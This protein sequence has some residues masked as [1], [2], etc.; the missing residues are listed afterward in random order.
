MA[1]NEEKIEVICIRRLEDGTIIQK[2]CFLN[3]ISEE[4]RQDIQGLVI[5]PKVKTNGEDYASVSFT[6]YIHD[7]PMLQVITCPQQWQNIPVSTIQRNNCPNLRNIIRTTSN[8]VEP[9]NDLKIRAKYTTINNGKKEGIV[10]VVSHF[11]Q[12][13]GQTPVQFFEVPQAQVKKSSVSNGKVFAN[14]LDIE[15]ALKQTIIENKLS[16]IEEKVGKVAH[17]EEIEQ[18][19]GK[20]AGK[21][22][23][24]QLQMV[25]NAISNINVFVDDSALV[26]V[27]Q[28]TIEEQMTLIAEQDNETYKENIANLLKV[29]EDLQAKGAT[30]EQLLAYL[31]EQM[32]QV[33]ASNNQLT[34]KVLLGLDK[35]DEMSESISAVNNSLDTYAGDILG[36]IADLSSQLSGLATREDEKKIVEIAMQLVA[37]QTETLVR[38]KDNEFFDDIKSK[39]S[40]VATSTAL[41][42]IED[43]INT[44]PSKTVIL[45]KF[46]EIKNKFADVSKVSQEQL[47]RIISSLD[48]ISLDNEQ[49][50][51]QVITEI[52]SEFETNRSQQQ[53]TLTDAVA[54][55]RKTAL[56]AGTKTEA[57]VKKLFRDFAESRL[58][59][60]IATNR[61]LTDKL[62]PAIARME[63]KVD[64]LSDKVDDLNLTTS[65]ILEKAANLEVGNDLLLEGVADLQKDLSRLINNGSNLS[66]EERTNLSKLINA[67]VSDLH[68]RVKAGQ[69]EILDNMKDGFS[70]VVNAEQIEKIVANKVET[71][72]ASLNNL[73]TDVNENSDIVAYLVRILSGAVLK[74]L[75]DLSKLHSEDTKSIKEAIDK[76]FD[77]NKFTENMTAILNNS[78]LAK[79]SS[80]EELTKL[81]NTQNEAEV[82][83]LSDIASSISHLPTIDKIKEVVRDESSGL[84]SLLLRRLGL[85]QNIDDDTLADMLGDNFGFLNGKVKGME[86]TL[87]AI[88]TESK[89]KGMTIEDLKK[90]FS[91]QEGKQVISSALNV[92][93]LTQ[94]LAKI[95]QANEVRIAELQRAYE[96]NIQLVSRMA[97]NSINIYTG[98]YGLASGVIQGGGVIPSGYSAQMFQ[99]YLYAYPVSTSTPQEMMTVMQQQIL[100]LYTVLGLRPNPTPNPVD[101]KDDLKKQLEEFKKQQEEFRKTLQEE[102][103]KQ[104]E[105]FKKQ[106]EEINKK[107][108]DRLDQLE[109]KNKSSEDK[110]KDKD[111]KKEEEKNK[112]VVPAKVDP[113]IKNVPKE[114]NLKFVTKCLEKMDRLAEPKLTVGQRFRK[115]LKRH[116]L[117]WTAIG[118][119]AGAILGAGVGVFAA[120]G[121]APFIA[122]MAYFGQS[123]QTIAVGAG[124][125]LG[126][127]GIGEI[128]A[129]VTGFCK[130][131]RLYKKFLKR[132]AKCE[133]SRG[134]IEELDRQIEYAKEAINQTREVAKACVKAKQRKRVVKATRKRVKK[135]RKLRSKARVSK[136]KYK[137]VVENFMQAKNNLNDYEKKKGKTMAMQGNLEKVREAKAILES[138]LASA[139]TEEEKEEAQ[140]EFDD[141]L[142][143]YG[144]GID[145][146]ISKLSDEFKTGD[147]EAE[148]IIM[149]V[150]ETKT[151]AMEDMLADIQ[152]RNSKPVDKEHEIKYYDMAKVRN[153]EKVVN[154]K[155]NE[156]DKEQLKEILE[157][158]EKTNREARKQAEEF[159]GSS[160]TEKILEKIKD[161]KPAEVKPAGANPMS[162]PTAKSTEVKIATSE[163]SKKEKQTQ[164]ENI[165]N[166]VYGAGKQSGE[167]STKVEDPS[168]KEEKKPEEVAVSN[169]E[170]TR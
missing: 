112:K 26:G 7:F 21:I 157:N 69:T 48:S 47:D 31:N 90:Y 134:K 84:Y 19:I 89:N 58:P 6:K 132:K 25:V 43:K 56:E 170:H 34:T 168:K 117:A 158:A 146:D 30:E 12:S 122:N 82:K 76:I 113:V 55:L 3:E 87:N 102:L 107:I 95:E 167:S 49:V 151:K 135:L 115:W 106:Q 54:E 100:N 63:G 155:G 51:D 165:M 42:K 164:I 166:Y 14:K 57:E 22:T 37:E 67:Y 141:A 124:I 140:E 24:E 18:I 41:K 105:E 17:I 123:L 138:K 53:K 159:K 116:P 75:G 8:G 97:A 2:Q 143:E 68:D 120:G 109:Q 20:F 32:P 152:K 121:I 110:D 88:L 154:A 133:K 96:A 161:P 144:I 126:V 36:G 92:Q 160:Y 129:R 80:I 45:N 79:A 162:T 153:Y 10:E 38:E 27:V 118:I 99:P 23:T 1:Q 81:I 62:M 139:T 73:R 9:S 137:G 83:S 70:K 145:G 35:Q 104:Q 136:A 77:S 13:G 149:S 66:E 142:M 103:R 91:S 71:L 11:S 119:G 78:T 169:E 39:L 156:A 60:L 46:A 5:L 29:V 64:D 98:A 130:K 147:K 65:E 111:K 40:G 108:L 28:K 93:M 131:D 127:G 86:K 163:G 16:A 44:M 15:N 4:E 148:D 50:V 33:I 125:G 59:D 94:Q 114:D 85:S 128:I 101:T 61:K 52:K 150:Q 72:V 74:S